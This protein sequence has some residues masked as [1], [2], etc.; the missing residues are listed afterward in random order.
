MQCKR[1]VKTVLEWNGG[2]DMA[3]LFAILMVS[4][5]IPGRDSGKMMA[6]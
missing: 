2:Y 1:C 5:G 4:V 3:I 6:K